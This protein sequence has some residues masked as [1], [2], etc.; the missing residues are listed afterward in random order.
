MA[1]VGLRIIKTRKTGISCD[2]N[3]H[4]RFI[5]LF[6]AVHNAITAK[7]PLT[8]SAAAVIGIQVCIVALFS[9]IHRAIPAERAANAAFSRLAVLNA[10][11]TFFRQ[12]AE[13][14]APRTAAH[15][16][17]HDAVAAQIRAHSTGALAGRTIQIFRTFN[18][19]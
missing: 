4:A 17:I 2:T 15:S 16:G 7:F 18:P 19:A 8:G 3:A 6:R 13:R 14:A 10:I 12:R 9:G 5:A 1:C 11:I